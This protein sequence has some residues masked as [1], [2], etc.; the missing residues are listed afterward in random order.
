MT[1]ANESLDE[2]SAA[3][4]RE[5]LPRPRRRT[6]LIATALCLFGMLAVFA[7]P[8]GAQ[9][10]PGQTAFILDPSTTGP[11]DT[12]FAV[13]TGCPD[14]GTVELFVDG[15]PA[16]VGTASGAGGAFEI[17]FI[18]PTVPGQYT[19]SILCGG[20]TATQILSVLESACGFIVQGVPGTQVSVNAPGFQVG[21]PFELLFAPGNRPLGTGTIDSDPQAFTFTIPSDATPGNYE[22]IINGVA[23]N[24]ATR[25]IE[26]PVVVLAGPTVTPAAVTPAVTTTLPVTGGEAAQI[27][28]AALAMLAI[29]GLLALAARR[30][31]R[32]SAA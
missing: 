4:R 30:G 13:G 6:P 3:G 8:A 23:R 26:C 2:D 31:R 19:V 17:S 16:G 5:A 27:A 32:S 14:G 20:V 18:A 25:S 9:Y 24:D 21:T 7:A 22:L 29:G 28:K 12:V 15:V 1:R 10:T 11:G